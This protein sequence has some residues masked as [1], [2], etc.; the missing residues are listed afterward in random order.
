MP[1]KRGV[2]VPCLNTAWIR[3]SPRP[4]HPPCLPCPNRTAPCSPPGSARAG[5]SQPLPDRL[6]PRARSGSKTATPAPVEAGTALVAIHRALR[7]SHRSFRAQTEPS[8]PQL[9]RPATRAGRSRPLRPDRQLGPRPDRTRRPRAP[10]P[11][12]T[13]REVDCVYKATCL[14]SQTDRPCPPPARLD[15]EDPGDPAQ[16]GLL[17]PSCSVRDAQA[18]PDGARTR[19]RSLVRH[20]RHHRHPAEPWSDLKL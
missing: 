5:R 18:H 14:S 8:A 20:Q 6:V 19:A 10:V 11:A 1:P 17:D 15:D 3:G 2:S 16:H 12:G 13:S 9:P 7:G 4:S